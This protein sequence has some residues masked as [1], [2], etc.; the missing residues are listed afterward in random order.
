M[1]SPAPIFILGL[2]QSLANTGWSIF[3]LKPDALP[4]SL[5]KR[6][7]LIKVGTIKTKPDE[8]L[9]RR[10]SS[11]E[12]GVDNLIKEYRPDYVFLEVVF[13]NKRSPG[14][15]LNL[16]RVETTLL[17]YLH[18]NLIKTD[19]IDSLSKREHSWRKLFGITSGDKAESKRLVLGMNFLTPT[20]K[21]NNHNA[22]ACLIALTGLVKQ[23]YLTK[24]EL[25]TLVGLGQ[26]S[27]NKMD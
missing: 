14:D 3:C 23:N 26:D 20:P 22:D 1:F 12:E 15:F 27:L 25:F 7:D 4:L 24:E 5:N 11:I 18:R 16:I 2:D 21:L 8:P 9:I 17:N 6:I 13:I 19:S 10:L